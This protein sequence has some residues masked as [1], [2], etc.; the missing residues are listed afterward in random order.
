[1]GNQTAPFVAEGFS[2][3]TPS[4][5]KKY[6]EKIPPAPGVYAI[7]LRGGTEI[8]SRCDSS[9]LDQRPWAVRD[10]THLYT[11]ESGNIRNRLDDHLT[12]EIDR[13][14]FR[15]T[16]L[17]LQ[18]SMR[19]IWPDMHW[20]IEDCDVKLRHLIEA[21]ALIA[22][23][24]GDYIGDIEQDL[25]SRS[26]SPLNIRGRPQTPFTQLLTSSRASLRAE[27]KNWKRSNT[28]EALCHAA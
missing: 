23:K 6:P 20:N 16:L 10:F 2:L 7:M 21:N 19:A 13:S 8:L 24:R 11:G 1:M 25:I 12:G 15:L 5:I 3:I 18:L 9:L 26:R 27:L 28:S 14:G 17:S 22:F 4:L